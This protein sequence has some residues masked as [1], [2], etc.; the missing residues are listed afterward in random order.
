[1]RL[2]DYGLTFLAICISIGYFY[3]L[4]IPQ[5]LEAN[6]KEHPYFMTATQFNFLYFG[7]YISQFIFLVPLGVLV[8]SFALSTL[9]PIMLAITIFSESIIG[10]V[11]GSRFNG[12]IGVLVVLRGISGINGLGVMIIQGKLIDKFAH[13][14]YEYIMGLCLNLPN[15]FTAAN[16]LITSSIASNTGN[17]PLCFFVGAFTC[18]LSLLV[19]L[20]II[21]LF[22]SPA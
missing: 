7:T 17:L 18:A 12:Y 5:T 1:M 19:S 10:V 21:K 2:R 22:L 13:P 14:H 16:S 8:D 20:T 11:L 15:L 9:M 3:C 6:L 4:D